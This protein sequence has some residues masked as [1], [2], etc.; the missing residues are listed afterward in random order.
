MKTNVSVTNWRLRMVVLM[1]VF[2]VQIFGGIKSLA[3]N[4]FPLY[5][6]PTTNESVPATNVP[7]T[8]T[9]V[10][11]TGTNV[12][13][14]ETGPHYGSW[15]LISCPSQN[16]TSSVSPTSLCA[17]KGKAPTVP[18]VTP[19]TF[20][21]GQKQRS[22]SY[23]CPTTNALSQT[24][25]VSYS[26]SG[27]MWDPPLPS[28]VTNSFSSSAYV[29]LTSSDSN[30][31]AGG[32]FVIG[33]AS[34][35]VSC[36]FWKFTTN[37]APGQV[38]F[39]NVT[40]TTNVCF[41]SAVSGSATTVAS[42]AQQVITSNYTNA[43]ANVDTNN[44]PPTSITNAIPPTIVSNWWTGS[45]G[46]HSVSGSGANASFV[47]TNCGNGTLT[48]YARWRNGCDT[49]L[50]TTS[51]STNF[52]VRA[53][54]VTFYDQP[55]RPKA[56]ATN[57]P[58]TWSANLQIVCQSASNP[59]NYTSLGS[60]SYGFQIATNGTVTT[61]APTGSA[62]IQITSFAAYDS[63]GGG[64]CTISARYIGGCECT[65]ML[66]W[67]QTITTSYPL[68]GCTS[69]YNDPCPGDD[70]LPYYYTNAEEGGQHANCP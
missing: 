29:N 17:E 70:T 63:G 19:P 48:F 39:T 31:C 15:T 50:N 12:Y 10:P 37:C 23:D 7:P 41:G 11:P 64:G 60:I 1:V 52:V 53:T 40:V 9:N 61:T 57:G 28:I 35:T 34:W 4:S 24:G 30:L 27:V 68:G 25:S 42:N 49:N 20:S 69:P 45:V 59:S 65:N 14:T 6:I 26:V 32:R 47:P 54:I 43:C 36:N 8:G 46:T 38:N 3:L 33:T 58:I 66:R 67:V 22:I 2:A 5:S 13:C 51:T 21:N 18:T 62:S 55:K 56:D 44:C 16:N